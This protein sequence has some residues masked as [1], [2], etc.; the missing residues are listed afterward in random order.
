MAKL[1]NF[2]ITFIIPE[3]LC[4]YS[5]PT[6]KSNVNSE[7][8]A[9]DEDTMYCFC[10]RQSFGLMI[11]CDNKE[12]PYEWFHIDCVGIVEAPDEEW[13]CEHCKI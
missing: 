7:D 8:E 11:A 2:F 6:D 4:N 3:V 5:V 9:E 10:C 13:Y 12:C 1:H